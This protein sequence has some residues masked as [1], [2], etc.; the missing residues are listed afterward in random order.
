MHPL[1]RFRNRYQEN[2]RVFG[3]I[4]GGLAGA[5]MAVFRILFEPRLWSGRAPLAVWILIG[6][7]L[8]LGLLLFTYGFSIWRQKRLIENIPT[9]KVRSLA[10]GLVEV[11]GQ[12]QPKVL[13]PSPITATQCLYYRFLIERYERRG[14]SSQWV[15]VSQGAS[16][17]FFYVDDGTGRILVDPV[18]AEIN[19]NKDYSYTGHD[20]LGA[21]TSFF[22]NSGLFG[23]RMRYSEWYILPGD[24]IYVM[25]TVTKWKD[26]YQDRKF[27][28]AEKIKELKADGERL[29]QFDL[30]QDGRI[31]AQEW[32]L[33]RQRI[34][35]EIL[36]QELDNP[37]DEHDD[38]VI[39]RDPLQGV[40]IISDRSEK[41]L[42]RGKAI[43]AWATIVLGAAL[44]LAGVWMLASKI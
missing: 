21:A 3:G 43:Q 42:V 5:A 10:M 12:A 2:R 24:Q 18:E 26:A 6:L 31:D 36:R 7:G 8:A 44:F 16:T 22:K 27:A 4:L 14:R 37:R 15:V 33:A 25:G 32:E 30:D 34:E 23:Q 13:L 1:Q 39:A 17:N 11:C 20:S 35:Q 40:M 41:E 29:K 28:L 19:L 38:Y 9:S